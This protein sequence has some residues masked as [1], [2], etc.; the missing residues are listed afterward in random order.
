MKDKL[1]KQKIFKVLWNVMTKGDKAKFI[2]L[3]ILGIIASAAIL[4]PTQIVSLI[5]TKLSGQPVYIFG[6][7]IS[8]NISYIA[9]IVVGGIITYFMRFMNYSYALN[10]EKLIKRVVANFRVTTYDWLVVPR[11][12]MDLKMTQG[13]ALYRINQGPETITNV[14]IELFNSVIPEVIS[15]VIAF[16]Y[17]VFLDS[18][19]ILIMSAGILLVVV[20]VV[21]RTHLEKKISVRTEK[22]KSAISNNIANSITNLP[23]ISLYKSMV[24]ES[25][26]FKDKVEKFYTEQKKQVNLRW[27]YWATVRMIQVVSTFLVIYLCANKIYS[28]AMDVGNVIIVVNYVAQIF[29]PI[30]I[31]GYFSTTWLQCSVAV[32][33][34]YELKPEQQDLLPLES[35]I[36]EKIE[37]I[38]LL[39]VSIKNGDFSINDVNLRFDKGEMTVICGESGC[40]KSTIIKVICGLCEKKGGKIILNEE[41]EIK[42]AYTLVDKMSV[43]MQ[44]AYIFNRDARLNIFY[45]DGESQGDFNPVIQVLSMNNLFKRTYNESNEQNFENILSGGEKKRIGI[46]RALL[47][48]ADLYIFD[49]PTNDLDNKNA[50]NVLDLIESLKE[51]AIVIVVSH[52]NRVFSRADKLYDFAKIKKNQENEN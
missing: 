38:E 36:S 32:D 8:N 35:K 28:G 18:Q 50:N 13:D 48:P 2:L 30:Q 29:S 49:E 7:L 39:N 5:I 27:F 24:F 14:F 3:M 9:I 25:L 47:K 44:S 1:K 33:R 52:D 41:K 4:I 40:G 26:V 37:S 34:L 21:I 42:S 31:I 17:I 51:N 16:V 6:C 11:K 45:P 46:S 43:S 19:T 23:L 22:A 15:A 10:M 20:C 12:N